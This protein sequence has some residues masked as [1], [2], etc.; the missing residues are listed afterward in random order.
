MRGGN[1]RNG[2]LPRAAE[3]GRQHAGGP[4]RPRRVARRGRA[5]CIEIGRGDDQ[6]RR[7]NEEA[8]AAAGNSAIP[9]EE[10]HA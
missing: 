6:I 5:G 7:V 4:R 8:S 9:T 1:L 2:G 10:E 3:D